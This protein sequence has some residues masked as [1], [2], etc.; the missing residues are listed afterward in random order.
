MADKGG[1]KDDDNALNPASKSRRGFLKF[2][3][4]IASEPFSA[5]TVY[6]PLRL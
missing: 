3:M 1:K 5:R 4:T 6:A 2:A